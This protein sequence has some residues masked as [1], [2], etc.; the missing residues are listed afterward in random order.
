MC[1]CIISSHHFFNIAMLLLYCVLYYC[2]IIALLLLYYSFIIE[3]LLC[4]H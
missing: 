1:Y 2:F 4:Y 3:L